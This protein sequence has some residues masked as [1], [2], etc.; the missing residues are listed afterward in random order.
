MLSVV[1]VNVVMLRAVM[2]NAMVLTKY[3]ND[4]AKYGHNRVNQNYINLKNILPI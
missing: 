1:M 2:L 4:V 3:L